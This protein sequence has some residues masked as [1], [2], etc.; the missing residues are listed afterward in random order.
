MLPLLAAL[1]ALLAAERSGRQ[2]VYVGVRECGKC[3]EGEKH[4]RQLSLW[5]Q[6]KHAQAYAALATP[7]ARQ[8]A[9]LSGVPQDPQRSPVCLGCHASGAHAES[10]ERDDTFHVED[11]V[12]CETCH[13]PGSEYMDRKIMM[14]RA[15]A[16]AAGLQR[17]TLRDCLG[18]HKEKGSHTAVL[19]RP[20]VDMEKAW[21]QIAHPVP[22]G[23]KPNVAEETTSD[24]P[25]APAFRSRLPK[26]PTGNA[27]APQYVGS[28]ACA[29]CHREAAFG[30]QYSR[31]RMSKHAMAYAE[32]A[33]PAAR[34][35]AE[36]A[37]IV[38]DPQHSP[39]CLKCHATAYTAPAGGTGASYFVGE[40]VGCEA[41]HGAGSKYQT[42]VV[43]RDKRAAAKAGLQTVDRSTCLRCHHNAH[44][45]PF[46]YEETLAK[47]AHPTKIPAAAAQPRYKTPRNLALSPN[48]RELYVTCEASD[49]VVVVDVAARRKV[50]EIAVGRQPEDVTFAPDGR[51]A[52]VSNR[53]DD[54][55]SVVDTRTRKTVAGVRVGG[56]PHGLLTD[57]AG[58]RLY[59]LNTMSDSI[60]V[61]D[62]ATLKETKR[63]T[64]SRGAWSLAL[65]PDGSR[66]LATNNLSRF[67]KFRTPPM[68]EITVVD[69]QSATVIDRAVAPE[70]NLLQG[71]DWHPSGE[72]ALFTLNRTK[73]LVPMTRLLQ[74]WTITSGLGIL[75]KDGRVD[76]VL[77]DEPGTCFPDPT[78]VAVTPDGRLAL[79]TSSSTD[80]VAVVDLAKLTKLL[81]SSSDEERRDVLPNHLGKPTEF[82]VG[83]IPTGTC[84]RGILITPDGRTAFVAN[85]LDDSLTVLDVRELEA[86]GRIDLGGPKEITKARYGERVFNNAK[87]A[88]HRQFSCHTCHP[89]GHVDGLTYD[90]EPDGI[91]AGPVDNRTLRGILD[92]APFKWEGTNPSLSRQCG[93]R[94]AVF[95]SRVQPFTPE[96]LSALDYYICTIPRPPNR[97]RPLGAELTAA[98]RRGKGV[99]DRTQTNDRR[100][101]PKELRCV[102]CHFPPLYTDRERHDVGTKMWLD[103]VADFDTPHL[104]NIYDSAPYLHNGIAETLEEIWT[105]YNPYDQHGVT[106]DLTK[107]QLNDL[108]EY[109]KTL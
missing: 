83:H 47:I 19:K 105:K 73:N 93:A 66:L 60:S 102:T 87:N 68:S 20:P 35:M 85:S 50:A 23:G 88:F 99:F 106:N 74:G 81:K 79:V 64:A 39:E 41:C 24:E 75:W 6:T 52:F 59:V 53:L 58:K 2:A 96:E 98:Q 56:E 65:S 51:R 63:L 67:V 100:P 1:A 69:T 49:T 70:T 9:E 11:G 17:P 45:K 30:H 37:G 46:A 5:L 61:I 77:L 48:G 82:V 94:L 16:E 28:I 89:D 22:R 91:G 97:Y 92:T 42:D 72:F 71:I 86:L 13:G 62:T 15:A 104:S 34:T 107:D 108:I 27:D 109:L 103:E 95:F 31:W 57:R 3:H 32:L 18:C 10:W 84:P 101:I 76:Q 78:D 21:R 80:R 8:I 54:T 44:G 29:T 90:T 55:V 14:N 12:Q 36:K 25:P 26:P 40:G 33:T 43:M 38:G 4:G 7:E